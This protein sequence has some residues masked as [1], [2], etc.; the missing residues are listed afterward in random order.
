M[1]NSICVFYIPVPDEKTGMDI[2]Q[3]LLNQK[4]IACANLLPQHQ[5]L[6]EWEGKVC[7]EN[8]NIL[9]L[10]THIDLQEQVQTEVEKLHPYDCP[11]ILTFT[12]SHGNTGFIDW[13]SLQTIHSSE[14]KD[15]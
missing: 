7:K 3:T 6:Y 1:Q 15:G 8:E 5:S 14:S 10:K 2:A 13:I 9:I 11:C 4:L 12:P